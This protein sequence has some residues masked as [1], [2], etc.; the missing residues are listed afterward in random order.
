MNALCASP[1]TLVLLALPHAQLLR[2]KPGVSKTASRRPMAVSPHV[3]HRPR[4]FPSWIKYARSKSGNNRIPAANGFYAPCAA[5]WVLVVLFT[6]IR[7]SP[8]P[9]RGRTTME[10]W[11]QILNFR[12][13]GNNDMGTAGRHP[14]VALSAP[15]ATKLAAKSPDPAAESEMLKVETIQLFFVRS[16]LKG[17]HDS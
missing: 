16:C 12:A 11:R 4:A 14:R 5:S 6:Q 9:R 10:P 8:S 13:P 3:R 17:L 2:D 1:S 15:H 7:T